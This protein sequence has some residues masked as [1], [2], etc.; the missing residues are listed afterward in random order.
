MKKINYYLRKN[1]L[2]TSEEN[3]YMACIKNKETLY[4][5]DLINVMLGKNTTVTRQDI[6]VVLDLMKESL[7][8]QILSGYSINTEL[9]KTNLSINGGFSSMADEFDPNLH[10][11]CVNMN[12]SSEFKRELAFNASV[13]RV[14]P[15]IKAPLI[16]Q[17]YDFN[18][19]SFTSDLS[20]GCLI[21]LRG[22][23]LKSDLQDSQVYFLLDGSEEMIP[24]AKIHKV[25]DR[26]ILCSLPEDLAAG[27][28]W[29]IAVMGEGDDVSRGKYHSPVT[30]S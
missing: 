23:Y 16:E 1:Q 20:A 13:E 17:I 25:T 29:V 11:V 21:E 24:A 5:E 15:S 6:I 9:F 12:A 19:K 7:K 30:I 10:Q 26:S 4:Q 18:S 28:Y 3:R 27:S 14:L 22:A 2:S 8:E